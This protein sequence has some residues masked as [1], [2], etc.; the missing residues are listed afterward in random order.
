MT[1]LQE[2]YAQTL[3]RI[4]ADR[5]SDAEVARLTGQTIEEFDADT[6]A[7]DRPAHGTERNRRQEREYDT[8]TYQ[9]PGGETTIRYAAAIFTIS[10]RYCEVCGDWVEAKGIM[11]ALLC[12]ECS[13]PWD[14]RFRE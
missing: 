3:A 1:T 5:Q 6:T 9:I 14:S 4:E 11:G 12:V 8:V 10:E 2:R 7:P 13:T